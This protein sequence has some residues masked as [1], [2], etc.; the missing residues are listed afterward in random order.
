MLHAEK[1]WGNGIYL[2]IVYRFMVISKDV[3]TERIRQVGRDPLLRV[4]WL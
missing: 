4:K 2:R 3:T 1:C